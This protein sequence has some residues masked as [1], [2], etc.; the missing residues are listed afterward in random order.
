MKLSGIIRNVRV[1]W[2]MTS[3]YCDILTSKQIMLFKAVGLTWS[4]CTDLKESATLL[5]LLCLGTKGFSWNNR[6]LGKYSDLRQGIKMILNLWQ[7]TF[8]TV[9][10]GTSSK[11]LNDWFNKLDVKSTINQHCLLSRKYAGINHQL[12]QKEK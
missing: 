2:R 6:K 9:V 5:I 3:K 10:I 4:D 7:V 11:S 8:G 12:K 1:Y